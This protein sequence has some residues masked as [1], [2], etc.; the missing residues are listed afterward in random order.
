M[1]QIKYIKLS[2][3]NS[4]EPLSLYLL[5]AEAPLVEYCLNQRTMSASD[6]DSSDGGLAEFDAHDHD[7]EAVEEVNE[8]PVDQPTP[9]NGGSSHSAGELL[10]R[11]EITKVMNSDIAIN[12]LLTRL[13]QSILVCEEFGKYIRKKTLFETDHTQ[14]LSKQYKHF[15]QAVGSSTPSL[16]RKI[17]DIIAFDGKMA[18]VKESYL[19]ALT[20]MHNEINA[21][22]LTMTRMR[23]RVKENSRRLE[24]EVSDS[25]HMAEKAQGRYNSLC[26]DWDKVRMTDPTKTKLTLRGSKTTKEQEEELL[27]KIDAQDLDY[28]QKVDHSTAL[29]NSFMKKERPKIVAELKHLILEIDTAMTIQLQKYTIWTENLILN[30][31]VTVTPFDDSS[32][33]SMKAIAASVANEKDL[34]NYLNK[35]NQKSSLLVNK[36]LIPVNYKKHPSMVKQNPGQTSQK[37]K[38]A[39][40]PSR[41]SI[42]KRMI[43]THNETPFTASNNF[44][45]GNGSPI[46]LNK[47]EASTELQSNAQNNQNVHSNGSSSNKPYP[48]VTTSQQQASEGGKLGSANGTNLASQGPGEFEANGDNGIRTNDPSFLSLD[49]GKAA[50]RLPSMITSSSLATGDTDRPISHVQTNTT[51]PPGVQNNFKTFGV[52]LEV[53]L[54][55]EQDM[56]P[57]VVR[58]C[59]YVVDQYGLKLEGI[60]RKSANVLD[61]AKLKEDIDKDPSNVSMILPPKNY[62]DTDIYLVGSLLKAFFASLPDS[63]L[64]RS[65]SSEIS[66]CIGLED[67][68]TKK[69]YMHGL[70]YKLPDAQ[71]WTLR[72]LLFHLK[73]V[74]AMEDENRMNIKSL[75]IIWGPTVIPPNENDA[76]DV[77]SQI[78]AMEVLIDVADQAFEPE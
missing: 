10:N 33:K 31:G 68:Q 63:L 78:A 75:C 61:I 57:A 59:I 56:V 41:N 13:K 43:S 50:A 9:S 20:T 36:N 7:H 11:P 2:K 72:A 52:P 73:R 70:I 26:Q 54:E 27:R 16:T 45:S 21:L 64:P 47:P 67:A 51:M 28:K 29:R 42:P 18:Q 49:P 22:L 4:S 53:L 37:P 46:S 15:F 32:N 38:F 77:N 60:Y 65:I 48:S 62:S 40:D 19:K 6:S 14:E 23:K 66:M 69:N 1:S 58:Q 71:Y 8:N 17:H 74:I 30:T 5:V 39:V 24:K 34:Y 25:I 44:S 35:Y 3:L 76:N 12:A 55:Y